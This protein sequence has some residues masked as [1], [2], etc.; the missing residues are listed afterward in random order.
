MGC[1]ITVNLKR[2]TDFNYFQYLVKYLEYGP[3]IK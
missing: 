2:L 1:K 3:K